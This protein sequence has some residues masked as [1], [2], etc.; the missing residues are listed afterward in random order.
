ME[1]IETPKPNQALPSLNSLFLPQF[2][3]FIETGS[4]LSYVREQLSE[5][6]VRRLSGESQQDF[7]SRTGDAL[8]IGEVC[9]HDPVKRVEQFFFQ[10][11]SARPGR[12]CSPDCHVAPSR[13]P[14]S[15]I[16]VDEN[17]VPI[18]RRHM[19]VKI[20]VQGET[21]SYFAAMYR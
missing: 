19:P 16:G 8:R 2:F 18:H 5:L 10:I 1:N 7:S 14:R 3:Q 13:I 17:L 4:A 6:N 12:T 20:S 21:H 11:H 15:M 9:V